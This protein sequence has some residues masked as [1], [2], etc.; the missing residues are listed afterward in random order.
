[1]VCLSISIVLDGETT[2]YSWNKVCWLDPQHS[3]NFIRQHLNETFNDIVGNAESLKE[4]KRILVG[5]N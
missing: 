4:V 2:S 3:S 5:G 1:M